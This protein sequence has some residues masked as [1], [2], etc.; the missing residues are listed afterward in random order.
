M[1]SDPARGLPDNHAYHCRDSRHNSCAGGEQKTSISIEADSLSKNFGNLIAVDKVS[2][3]VSKGEIFGLVGP[4]GA[5]KSTLLKM[6]CTVLRPTSG[7]GYVEGHDIVKEA[8]EV[9]RSIGV[10]Q[11][12]L[13]LYSPLTPI[14]N[15]EFFG[16]LYNMDS[17]ILRAKIME[18]LDDVKLMTVK[19]RPVGTFSTGMRQRLNIARAL[20]HD[21]RVVILDEPTNG[22]DPQSVRWVRDFI[23]KLKERGLTVVLTTHDMY[24]IDE[25]A[26]VVAIMDRGQI[27]EIGNK[28]ELK[29]RHGV[30]KIEDV[31]LSLTGRELRD[32]LS[33]RLRGR[34]W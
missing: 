18:L 25:L 19:D 22:L 14:E 2:F 13:I 23:I 1:H 32:E 31:F 28:D 24:E 26:E 16:N 5:G 12:K 8:T 7:K 9:R 4:N 6:L 27:L 10:V 11:E 3:K 34:G 15:L 30:D 21:P 33:G 20:L 17:K 29:S